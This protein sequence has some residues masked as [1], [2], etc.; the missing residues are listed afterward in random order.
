MFDG[1]REC[2][3]GD[4]GR[5]KGKEQLGGGPGCTRS[6]SAL[7]RTTLQQ[8]D[9]LERRELTPSQ[10][11]IVTAGPIDLARGLNVGG[12]STSSSCFAEVALS[13]AET[14][15]VALSGRQ[16]MQVGSGVGTSVIMER[17]S[18]EGKFGRSSPRGPYVGGM[19]NHA[20]IWLSALSITAHFA[21]QEA[22]R[23]AFDASLNEWNRSPSRLP[24]I[25]QDQNLPEPAAPSL[26]S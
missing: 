5:G 4:C 3:A 2:D 19:S 23:N 20:I 12:S 25:V 26:I 18:N 8:R 13:C 17:L 1:G 22:R 14:S 15:G 21:S 9:M 7:T 24:P 11:S 16:S 10:Y 6:P